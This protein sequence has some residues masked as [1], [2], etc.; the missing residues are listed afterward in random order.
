M[1]FFTSFVN[2]MP[3]VHSHTWGLSQPPPLLVVAM[4]ACGALYVKTR[5]ANAFIASTLTQARDPL[6]AQFVRACGFPTEIIPLPL[7]PQAK[8]TA[9]L[10]DR[11]CTILA[12][13]LLQTLGLFHQHSEQ[14]S[15]A[16]TYHSMLVSVSFLVVL[17]FDYTKP[18]IQMIR[19]SGIMAEIA[20]WKIPDIDN[21]S[22]AAIGEAWRDWAVVEMGKRCV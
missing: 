9:T 21:V 5:A 10:S 11:I 15:T 8:D 2:Q 4:Q 22:N 12:V 7:H 19:K 17:W 16:M 6:V 3:M 13:A 14:R 18:P 20:A 1:L